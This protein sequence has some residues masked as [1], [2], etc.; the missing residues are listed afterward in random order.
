MPAVNPRI[1]ITLTPALH[2]VLRRLS[3][4]TGNSQSALVGGLLEQ[5]MPVLE[6]MATVLDAAEKLKDQAMEAPKEIGASMERA[7]QRI[8]AQIGLALDDM[9]AGFRPLIDHAESVTRRS[10]GAG[11][12]RRRAPA[13]AARSAATPMSNRGVTPHPTRASK[14]KTQAKKGGR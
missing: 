10:A 4:L 1:T 2:A 5:S 9:D 8:E 6:R 7:Q 13:T 3:V 12:A 11:D 14:A